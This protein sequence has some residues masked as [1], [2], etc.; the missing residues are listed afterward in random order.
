[1]RLLYFDSLTHSLPALNFLVETMG[2]ERVMLGTD[3]PADMM[4][5]DPVKTISSLSHVSDGE[6]EMTYSGNALRLLKISG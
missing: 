3:Y 2:P 6:K 5:S 1:L 4:D